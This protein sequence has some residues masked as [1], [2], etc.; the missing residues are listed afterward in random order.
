MKFIFRQ[1]MAAMTDSKSWEAS[2]VDSYW[3]NFYFISVAFSD[4]TQTGISGPN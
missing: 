3:E 1:M 4:S 2:V